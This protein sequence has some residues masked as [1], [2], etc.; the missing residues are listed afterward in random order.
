VV[1]SVAAVGQVA[2]SEPSSDLFALR[3]G[4]RVVPTFPAKLRTPGLA[5]PI[6]FA[7][8]RRS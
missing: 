1:Q 6:S 2:E 7:P 8:I 3:S 4:S 5:T